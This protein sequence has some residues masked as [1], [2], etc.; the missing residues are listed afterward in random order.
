[1]PIAVAL[2]VLTAGGV[3]WQDRYVSERTAGRIF[4]DTADVPHR[5]VAL[6]L[7]TS[8]HVNGRGNL[9]YRYCLQAAARLFLDGKVQAILVSR[10]NS[11]KAYNEPEDFR[12]DLVD[13]GVPNDFITLDSIVRARKVFGL[14]SVIVVSQRFHCDRALYL[15]DKVG[16]DVDGYAARDVG[17]RQGHKVRCREALSRAKAFLD[18]HV[19]GTQ[20]RF[21]GEPVPVRLKW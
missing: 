14:D 6:L 21:L 9:F 1:M 2:V 13:L 17:G 15:A 20:P 18:L 12:R 16:L 19:L 7:G 11:R 5:P 4:V 8:K 10:D 3:F